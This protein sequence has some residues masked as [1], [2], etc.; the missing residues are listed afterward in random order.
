MEESGNKYV[1]LPKYLLFTSGHKSLQAYN[2]SLQNMLT[3]QDLALILSLSGTIS[4]LRVSK[5]PQLLEHAKYF[6]EAQIA[7]RVLNV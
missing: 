7:C 4:S 5:L 3:K 6:S 2:E 1:E